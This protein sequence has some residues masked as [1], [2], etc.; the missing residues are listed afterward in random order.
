MF[1]FCSLHILLCVIT[2]KLLVAR[3]YYG[4]V[5]NNV[6]YSVDLDMTFA[7]YRILQ[8]RDFTTAIYIVVKDI[9]ASRRP[10]YGESAVA[11]LGFGIVAW[12]LIAAGTQRGG[13]HVGLF[14]PQ[15]DHPTSCNR[16]L[17]ENTSERNL[18]FTYIRNEIFKHT[19][20]NV[21]NEIR[22]KRRHSIFAIE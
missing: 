5:N 22:I 15:L 10:Q 6:V 1:H 18:F 16:Q 12:V 20:Q 19:R 13:H 2:Y 14:E 8:S 9:L 17:E 7:F 3:H 4:K 11:W 21:E